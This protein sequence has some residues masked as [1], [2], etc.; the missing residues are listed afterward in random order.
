M[1]PYIETELDQIRKLLV[2]K[3]RIKS[4]DDLTD[5]DIEVAG[6]IRRQEIGE[7]H[8][9][10]SRCL[11]FGNILRGFESLCLSLYGLKFEIQTPS[12]EEIWAGSVLRLVS[13]QNFKLS[14]I[15]LFFRMSIVLTIFL[16]QF[17]SM[18]I[19]AK[20]RSKVTVILLYVAQNW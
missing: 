7:S 17:M 16:V 15:Q 6:Y 19:T 3:K 1:R 12:L 18:L 20:T 9:N 8:G 14:L 4:T 11:S 13:Q 2:D 10:L 5:W